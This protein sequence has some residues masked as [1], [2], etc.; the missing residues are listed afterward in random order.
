MARPI[1][2]EFSGAVYHCCAR[3]NPPAGGQPIFRDKEGA[4]EIR[5]RARLTTEEMTDRA[6]SLVADEPDRRVR[7]W[8]RACLGGE[9]NSPSKKCCPAVAP[10]RHGVPRRLTRS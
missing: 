6:R 5:W 1:R 9:P 7:I 8:V 2:V 3:G 10:G 4:D